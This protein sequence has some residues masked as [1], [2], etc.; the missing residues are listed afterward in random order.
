MAGGAAQGLSEAYA[1]AG[2]IGTDMTAKQARE[3]MEGPAEKRKHLP[4][5]KAPER[6]AQGLRGVQ[7][8]AYERDLAAEEHGQIEQQQ[9]E[10]TEALAAR[11]SRRRHMT[12]G[13]STF[14]SGGRSPTG[15]S[16]ATAPDAAAFAATTEDAGG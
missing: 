6:K 3:A 4:A 2:G 1:G 15:Q 14:A 11:E 13:F 7:G 9:R 8:S 16:D 5:Y 12:M 10:N